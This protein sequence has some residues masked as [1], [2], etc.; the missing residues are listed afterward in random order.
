MVMDSRNASEFVEKVMEFTNGRGVDVVLNSLAGD[1]QVCTIIRHHL[2]H[3]PP[4]LLMFF[5][6]FPMIRR[7]FRGLESMD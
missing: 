6:I 5:D 3:F 1:G 4:F 7:S 2:W